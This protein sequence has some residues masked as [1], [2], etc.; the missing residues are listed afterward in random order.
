LE[1][2]GYGTELLQAATPAQVP[3]EGAAVLLDEVVGTVLELRV[4]V[5]EG[6]DDPDPEHALTRMC[7][8]IEKMRIRKRA[9]LSHALALHSLLGSL[10]GVLDAKNFACHM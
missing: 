3:L 7:S 2:P 9:E 10:A 1:P 4:L 5:L 8:Q 6:T